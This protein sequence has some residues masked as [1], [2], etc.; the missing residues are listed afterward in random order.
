M[1]APLAFVAA[2]PEH[3]S[4]ALAGSGAELLGDT[5]LADSRIADQEDQA[6]PARKRFVEGA[7]QRR[8]RLLTTDE[9]SALTSCAR[10]G[11]L[12]ARS[13]LVRRRADRLQ[14]ASH[15]GGALFGR[16]SG[17]FA[18]QLQDGSASRAAGTSGLKRE[19]GAG[20]AC[21]CCGEQDHGIGAVERQ[22]PAHHL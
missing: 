8:H 4:A 1:P 13:Q 19:G 7:V 6:S 16:S 9:A 22:V 3:E 2:S 15:R 21:R 17:V 14:R 18:E 20:V 10:G 12:G 5:C 11:W